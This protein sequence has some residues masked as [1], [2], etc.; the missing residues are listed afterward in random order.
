MEPFRYSARLNYQDCLLSLD[1]SLVIPRITAAMNEQVN[2]NGT[3]RPPTSL[4]CERCRNEVFTLDS[5]RA[6]W[7]ATGLYGGYSYTTTWNDVV[8]AAGLG[9]GW[10]R[11]LQGSGENSQ[12]E[13]FCNVIMSFSERN[14]SG[15]T[16]EGVAHLRLI[17][18][19]LHICSFFIYTEAGKFI[20]CCNPFHAAY[21]R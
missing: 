16:P 1:A 9:C 5:F 4:V 11:V 19:Q 10:C 17:I 21:N 18:N 2:A 20:D 13:L 6:A 14:S 3:A 7:S 15:C 8:R 12:R